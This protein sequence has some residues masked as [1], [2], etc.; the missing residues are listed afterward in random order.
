MLIIGLRS[1]LRHR[2]LGAR[3]IQNRLLNGKKQFK[4]HFIHISSLSLTVS[5]CKTL[6]ISAIILTLFAVKDN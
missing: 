5:M 6:L 4:I 3:F 2:V 1:H